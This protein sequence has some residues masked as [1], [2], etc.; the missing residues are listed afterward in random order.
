MSN[1]MLLIFCGVVTFI[2]FLVFIFFYG[3]PLLYLIYAANG[4]FVEW[5]TSKFGKRATENTPLFAYL[6]VLFI[7]LETVLAV[8]LIYG[9]SKLVS[10]LISHHL[11]DHPIINHTIEKPV[12]SFSTLLLFVIILIIL[13][14]IQLVRYFYY[15]IRLYRKHKE[16]VDAVYYK[17]LRE[18]ITSYV[19]VYTYLI[20]FYHFFRSYS[21]TSIGVIPSFAGYLYLPYLLYHLCKSGYSYIKYRKQIFPNFKFKDVLNLLSFYVFDFF[22]IYF[23]CITVQYLWF[24]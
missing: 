6:V 23:F 8:S 22:F 17:N 20:A 19:L 24:F 15:T 3:I 14:T 9:A 13:K 7:F 12:S 2:I 10:S 16:S 11:A 21:A 4:G 5:L 1:L 18:T